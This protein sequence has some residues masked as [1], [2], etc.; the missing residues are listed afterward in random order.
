MK[1]RNGLYILAGL[2]LTS[3]PAIAD[4]IPSDFAQGSSN[5]A[6]SQRLPDQRTLQGSSAYPNFSASTL[7]LEGFPG[8]FNPAV[9]MRNVRGER[10]ISNRDGLWNFGPRSSD[11]QVSLFDLESNH[12]NAFGWGQDKVRGHHDR[13]HGDGD[14]GVLPVVITP[15]PGSRTL[16]LLGLAGLGMIVYRRNVLKNAI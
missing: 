9:K 8:E 15:E 13:N 14:I 10:K 6:H 7:G 1:H 3:V 2:L 12:G 16:L 5:S 4:R 11:H